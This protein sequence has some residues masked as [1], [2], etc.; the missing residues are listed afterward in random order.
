MNI[1]FRRLMVGVVSVCLTGCNAGI[2]PLVKPSSK[3]STSVGPLTSS[4]IEAHRELS[5]ERQAVKL[6]VA[7]P[8]FDAGLNSDS[9]KEDAE[10]VWPE[11]RRA[12]AIRFTWKLKEALE[13]TGHFSTVRVVPDRNATAELYVLG[14]IIKSTGED[15]EIGLQVYDITGKDLVTS[16]RT[17]NFGFLSTVAGQALSEKSFSHSVNQK[18]FD[19]L[20]NKGKDSYQPIFD[21]SANYITSL[22][23]D[24]ST[25]EA[26]TLKN[27]SDLRF[28]AS[29]SNEAFSE[30]LRTADDGIVSLVSMPSGNDTTLKKVRSIRV[31]DQ[32]FVDKLQAEYQAFDQKFAKTHNVWQE[33]TLV[34]AAARSKAR[35]KAA[36]QAIGA[37]LL[38]GLAI[39]AGQSAQDANQNYDSV[40]AT[41]GVMGATIAGIGAIKM[42]GNSVQ[43]SKEAEMHNDLIK[44]LG[45]SVDL[46]VAPKV[47][48][49]EETQAELVGT[50]SEQFTQWRT[51]LKKIYELE[52]TP[53]R[54]L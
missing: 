9:S 22:L 16:S 36:G 50:A 24:I 38:L 52:K 41:V 26:N 4:Q 46:E 1:F 5:K 15:V 2:Q 14:R 51:F 42:I 3:T 23:K 30:H 12:E 39:A 17:M 34:E 49:F 45:Q 13:R 19:D 25:T 32:L 18:F 28:A 43:S 33:Q 48:A 29:M 10:N 8:I 35:G 20:R 40:G 7:I 53:N 54:Q 37:V 6:D 27:I 47:V 21:Q 31:R 11:L 44:E